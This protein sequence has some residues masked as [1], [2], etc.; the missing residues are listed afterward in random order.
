VRVFMPGSGVADGKDFSGVAA[1]NPN[2][3]FVRGNRM[4][5]ATEVTERDKVGGGGKVGVANPDDNG[6]PNVGDIR[7][8]ADTAAAPNG[9]DSGVLGV[10]LG[11]G[12]GNQIGGSDRNGWSL[13]AV[14]VTPPSGPAV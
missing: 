7:N 5:Q 3:Y 2:T 13:A 1:N 4:F 14:P 8:V 6:N 10:M 11:D 9:H 12:V